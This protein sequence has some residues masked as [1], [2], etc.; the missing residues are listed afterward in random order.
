MNTVVK[1]LEAA[2]ADFP[3]KKALADEYRS[4]T[5]AQYR[6]DARR[7][8]DRIIRDISKGQIKRPVAVLISRTV[9]PVIAFMGIV[10]S[11]NFYVPIDYTL[12]EERRNL[13]L[14]E[15]DPL[16]IIDARHKEDV[17]EGTYRFE[18]LLD[19]DPESAETDFY[20]EHTIDTDP[21]YS[22][23]TSGSTGVPKGVLIAHRG[24]MDLVDVFDRAFGFD[25]D[26]IFGNQAP[27]DF[28]VSVK[29]IYNSLYHG[30]CVEVLPH[31]LFVMPKKLVAYLAER[32]VDTLI[33]AVSAVRIIS[34]FKAFDTEEGQG[35]RGFRYVMFSGEVMPPKTINYWMERYPDA[36]YVNLY[37]PTE[38]TCNC[39]YK[40]ID[41][42]YPNDGILPAGKAF[43]NTRI[44]LLDNEGNIITKQNEVGEICVEGTGL[45]LGYYNNPEKTAEA[46]RRLP[47]EKGYA[48]M[49][50][51]TG[52]LGYWNADMD[53]VFANRA[54]SQIKHMGHRIELGEIEIALN[55]MPFI[56]VACCIY[57]TKRERIVCVYQAAEEMRRQIVGELGKKLPKYMWPNKYIRYDQIPM[58]SHGKIDRASLRKMII[59][60]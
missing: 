53:I 46:F 45:A 57:D 43:E 19:G 56:T 31:K 33:W 1:M 35:I 59:K 3:D 13:I 22:I 55:A 48:D 28:D 23:F 51:H 20:M 26:C 52:D 15:L 37:G 39:T 12:P 24:V 29:D 27:F 40:V 8:A 41:H 50:Y 36:M 47:S 4:V 42:M 34:D 60:D 58:N 14:Q 32:K 11:G 2:Y 5:Y 7:I 10:Y 21:L 54:D 17:I 44:Y 38:I 9:D 25:A 49:L 16:G 30:A 18:D 6:N